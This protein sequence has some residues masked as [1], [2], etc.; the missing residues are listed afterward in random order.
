MPELPLCTFVSFLVMAFSVSSTTKD[1]K[2]H[3]GKLSQGEMNM[4]DRRIA[5]ISTQELERRWKLVRDHMK[6]RGL[7]AL[8]VQTERDFTGG[9]VKWFTDVPAYYPRTVVF[10][11]SEL[12]T[13]VEHGAAGR[14]RSLAGNDADN[15]GV[16]D[17]IT[18]S[19]FPSV[20][21]TQTYDAEV[22]SEVL[23]RRGYRKIG[24][25]G[26]VGMRHGFVAYLERA[27]SGKADISDETEFVDRVKA[28][29]S[30]EEIALI[31]KAAAMQDAVFAKVLSHIKPGMR[32]L[33]VA[34]LA[35]Y[36]GQLL[37]SEQGI[38]LGMSAKL[39][40]PAFF[41]QRH[42]QGRTLRPGD[43]MSLLI[44]NNGGGGFYAEISRT[45]VLGKASQELIDGFEIVREAQA[46]TLRRFKPGAS[47]KEI[48]LAH[49]EFM[50]QN[51]MPAE[52]RVYSHSQGYDLI[53]RPLIR[54]DET[55]NLE[56]GMNMS[57]HPSYATSSM[58]A[59]ICDN[60]LV[61]E[62]G[63]SECLHKTPKKIFEL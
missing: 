7:G 30:D 28:V 11:A 10:H 23:S 24:L 48:S 29:K 59:H 18:T 47:C 51:G 1:T 57:V 27:Q 53:E 17:V 54:R 58:Y 46:Q 15:P 14:R 4:D 2:V 49:D 55:M 26:A 12:M 56:K 41:A 33:E 32:D 25:V 6:D 44:E 60:Y 13:V 5:R 35:Q 9:Y 61:E 19:A 39:G 22:V 36:E 42:F 52:S 21:Y 20:H 31:R 37:G 40:Q 63:V 38:F 8:I 3:K 62:N 43:H 50:R 16:G 45:I 34:A